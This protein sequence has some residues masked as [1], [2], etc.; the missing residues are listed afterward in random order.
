MPDAEPLHEHRSRGLD[1]GAWVPLKIM[2][3]DADVPVL[4]LSMPTAR[5]RPAARPGRA[6]CA[7]LRE[8]GVL[9]IGSGFMTHGLPFLDLEMIPT[10]VPG[11]SADF[12]AWAA[13][14]LARG[15]VDELARFRTAAPGHALRAPDGRALHAAVRHP[16]RRDRPGGRRSPRPSTAT[17]SASPSGPSRR[18]D[19]A[20]AARKRGNV[21]TS[22]A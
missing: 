4:Q 3:P 8:Q 14:A 12:D 21:A 13:D 2:Y 1:H 9:V 11:W 17:P 15:D 20:G 6:G 18:P 16:G 19:R 10:A 5:P 22:A 7:P